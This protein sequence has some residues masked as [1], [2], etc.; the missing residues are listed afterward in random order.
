VQVKQ[1]FI[2]TGA[3]FYLQALSA[4]GWSPKGRRDKEKHFTCEATGGIRTWDL[5][6]CSRTLGHSVTPQQMPLLGYIR[7]RCSLTPGPI[8]LFVA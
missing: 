6:V 3:Y 8:Q 4:K 7:M 5:L 1:N 2:V